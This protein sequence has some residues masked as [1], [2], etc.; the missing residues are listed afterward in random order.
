MTGEQL[1]R[2]TARLALLLYAATLGLRLSHPPRPSLARLL[3]TA[4]SFA[5]LLHV[6][7]AFQF[8]HHWSHSDAYRETARRT[9]ETVGT[10]S[11]W[12][13]YLNYLFTGVWTA[14][15]AWWWAL[16]TDAYRARPRSLRVGLD[17]FMAFMAFNATVVF[18]HGAT[19]WAGAFVTVLLVAMSLKQRL[20]R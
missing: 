10:P 3:W 16:G 4:G 9:A 19:R 8:F 18:G 20:R 6:A 1:T 15:V 13:L 2:W 12:G 17:A 14:D 11:G 7:A 5:F